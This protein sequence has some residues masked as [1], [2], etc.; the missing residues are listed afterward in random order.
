MACI[1]NGRITMAKLA[2]MAE[3]A[4]DETRMLILCAPSLAAG[5]AGASLV[6]FFG[7]VVRSHACAAY[8]RPRVAQRAEN[9]SSRSMIEA[10]AM[11]PPSQMAVSA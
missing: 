7:F 10:L 2:D 5:L 1:V 9:Q 8:A 11:P 3:K 4:L 6:V